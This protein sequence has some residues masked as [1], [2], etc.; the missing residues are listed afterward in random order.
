MLAIVEALAYTRFFYI[1]RHGSRCFPFLLTSCCYS[2][3]LYICCILS[4]LVTYNPSHHFLIQDSS[5]GTEALLV[6]KNF[7]LY[8]TLMGWH[9]INVRRRPRNL[10][11]FRR[12]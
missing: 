10:L 4:C 9:Y 5:Q 11:V 12:I 6:S 8:S 3:D 2:P 7:N 1:T